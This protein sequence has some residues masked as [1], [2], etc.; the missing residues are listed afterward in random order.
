MA[1]LVTALYWTEGATAALQ[2]GSCK[3]YEKK[4]TCVTFVFFFWHSFLQHLWC[5]SLWDSL[6]WWHWWPLRVVMYVVCRADLFKVVY[7]ARGQLT[8][9]QRTAL[10]AR[11]LSLWM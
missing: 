8:K 11:R 4:C 10:D 2:E 1:G 6:G 7:L 5:S 3:E 9:L